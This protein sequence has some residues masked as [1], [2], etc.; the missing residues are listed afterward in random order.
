MAAYE[1]RRTGYRHGNVN[2]DSARV[3]NCYGSGM[4][5][6]SDPTDQSG[7]P[8]MVTAA[9]VAILVVLAI[10]AFIAYAR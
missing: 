4:N 8:F 5:R 3:R 1:S 10:L 6:A 9:V 7:R 2:Q